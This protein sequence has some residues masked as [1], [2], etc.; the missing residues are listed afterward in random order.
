MIVY[1]GS[2][3]N[4]V[5]CFSSDFNNFDSSDFNSS[6]FDFMGGGF[7][8][9]NDSDVHCFAGSPREGCMQ[10]EDFTDQF[11]THFGVA[12]FGYGNDDFDVF[13]SISAD[14]LPIVTPLGDE[15]FVT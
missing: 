7:D 12:D 15:S 5:D 13:P 3:L 11:N 6:D 1:L 4:Y 8:S 10:F 2:L 9:F 14:V